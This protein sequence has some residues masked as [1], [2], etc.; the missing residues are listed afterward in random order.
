MVPYHTTVV[1][2]HFRQFGGSLIISVD[3]PFDRPLMHNCSVSPILHCTQ[4]CQSLLAEAGLVV[5]VSSIRIS[6]SVLQPLSF[7]SAL[8][9]DSPKSLNPAYKFGGQFGRSLNLKKLKFLSPK[10]TYRVAPT[11]TRR[12]VLLDSAHGFWPNLSCRNGV[13][14]NNL[15]AALSAHNFFL[16]NGFGCFSFCYRIKVSPLF[17]R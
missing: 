6:P 2:P 10:E 12:V 13:G 1:A 16:E 7:A 14:E 8:E 4:Q 3:A 17:P 15:S 5:Y 11:H 9:V